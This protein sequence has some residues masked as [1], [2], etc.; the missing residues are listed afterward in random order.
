[1]KNE[2]LTSFLESELKNLK[3]SPEFW[4]TIFTF[5][6]E[7]ANS[8]NTYLSDQGVKDFFNEEKITNHLN[9][10]NQ[11]ITALSQLSFIIAAQDKKLK[12]IEN[13]FESLEQENHQLLV[14]KEEDG[15]KF[16]DF[17]EK[18]ERSVEN[19][20]KVVK[21]ELNAKL[22]I[23]R[24]RIKT[25]GKLN[26]QSYDPENEKLEMVNVKISDAVKTMY[27]VLVETELWPESE[28][29]PEELKIAKD[30]L[31]VARRR[32][33]G[34]RKPS[35]TKEEEK[36]EKAKDEHDKLNNEKEIL[37]ENKQP[38][39]GKVEQTEKEQS[40]K[41]KE[42]EVDNLQVECDIVDI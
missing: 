27:Q 17:R 30:N 3:H 23:L 26:Q 18:M 7:K 1:M 20:E 16:A 8:Y 13:A 33:A 29:Q 21:R 9:Y 34:S 11:K 24:N 31:N 38:E 40:K 10:V 35:E 25:V 41:G 42:K 5:I 15:K 39:K 32:T 36:V 4:Q 19:R 6:Q 14:Q 28:N 22:D 2:E 37:M 12:Q